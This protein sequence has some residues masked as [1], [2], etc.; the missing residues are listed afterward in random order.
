MIIGVT[1]GVGC[2]KSTALDI[3]K[4]DFGAKVLKADDMGHE[5]MKKGTAAYEEILAE[6][7]DSVK[8]ENGELDRAALAGCIY[9]NDRK[10]EQLNAII[11]PRVTEEIKN[12]LLLWDNEPLVVLETALMFETGCNQLCSQVWG[13]D[14]GREERIRRLMKSRGYTRES[15]EAIMEKQ[16]SEE[17]YRE[18]CDV[19]IDNTGTPDALKERLAQLLLGIKGKI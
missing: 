16:L 3:L 8:G 6:F 2:G 13:I 14:A 9:G 5:V 19:I 4:N 11:H 7:G 17:E 10:R 1:G 15:A 18:R 12:R